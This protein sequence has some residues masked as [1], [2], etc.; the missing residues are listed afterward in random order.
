[1]AQKIKE[2]TFTVELK[3]ADNFMWRIEY[4]GDFSNEAAFI[5]DSG[6]TKDRQ[7]E[8]VLGLLYNFSTKQQSGEGGPLSRCKVMAEETAAR[9]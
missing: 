8:F 1:M 7:H 6:T 9:W 3:P 5:T 2:C 4:C